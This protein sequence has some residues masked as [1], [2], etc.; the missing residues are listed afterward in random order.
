MN[1][2]FIIAHAPLAQAMRACAVHVFP[3]SAQQILALDVSADTP[4][5][6]TVDAACA[7]AEQAGANL[8]LMTDLFGATPSNIAQHVLQHC[9]RA[10]IQVREVT[11][12]NVPMLLR[13]LCH[14]K[15]PLDK[16]EQCAIAGGE[17]GIFTVDVATGAPVCTL[18]PTHESSG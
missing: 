10:D 4:H 8:L 3:D 14:L 16:L 13:T 18:F 11:G 5:T 15:L 12:L 2:I 17:Q 9:T 1:K 6:Q 7:M